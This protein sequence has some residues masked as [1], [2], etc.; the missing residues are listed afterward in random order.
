M[1]K[2]GVQTGI[3]LVFCNDVSVRVEAGSII[4]L[5]PYYSG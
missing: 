1:I 4:L 2:R 5:P 3:L